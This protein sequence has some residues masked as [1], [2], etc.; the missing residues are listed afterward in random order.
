MV[1]ANSDYYIKMEL[2]IR[3]FMHETERVYLDR[4]LS[5]KD[6]EIFDDMFIDVVKKAPS[7]FSQ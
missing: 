7:Y 3:L 5:E 2:I 6:V 4:L 1:H